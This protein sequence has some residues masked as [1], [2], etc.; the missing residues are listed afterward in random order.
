MWT[1]SHCHLQYPGL[2]DD[3]FDRA[4]AASEVIIPLQ[5]LPRDGQARKND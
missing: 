3:F 1:D 4:A 5:V 2:P